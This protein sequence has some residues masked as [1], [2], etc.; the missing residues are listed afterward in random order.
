MGDNEIIV[1]SSN[2]IPVLP[3]PFAKTLYWLDLTHYFLDSCSADPLPDKVK[4]MALYQALPEDMRADESDLLPSQS[5]T[6]YND[7]MGRLRNKF[8][9]PMHQKLAILTNPDPIGDK[10]PTQYLKYIRKG[11]IEAGIPDNGAIK[12]AFAKGLQE[13]YANFVHMARDND[14]DNVALQ[15]DAMW[16]I[17]KI[18]TPRMNVLEHASPVNEIERISAEVRAL[19]DLTQRLVIGHERVNTLETDRGAG[20]L[21]SHMQTQHI[22]QEREAPHGT[23][24]QQRVDRQ[25]KR[26]N[27]KANNTCPELPNK[28]KTYGLCYFHGK[29]GNNAYRCKGDGCGWNNFKIPYHKC[30]ERICKWVKYDKNAQNEAVITRGKHNLIAKN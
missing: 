28:T 13:K 26:G 6:K 19:T 4:F 1:R 27:I 16:Q 18:S 29:F 2:I 12:I 7:L 10:S 24:V 20:S 21:H 11:Y 8:A 30:T 9:K 5:V 25:Y 23:V 3:Q 14:L 15:L 17:D 22:S